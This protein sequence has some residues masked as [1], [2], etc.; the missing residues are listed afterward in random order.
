MPNSN[1]IAIPTRIFPA[2]SQASSAAY[3]EYTV[4]EGVEIELDCSFVAFPRKIKTIGNNWNTIG[5]LLYYYWAPFGYLGNTSVVQNRGNTI[6]IVFCAALVE[7]PSLDPW[8]P[9]GISN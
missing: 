7:M 4:S 3:R 6:A 1:S 9:R 2:L 8:G 5:L